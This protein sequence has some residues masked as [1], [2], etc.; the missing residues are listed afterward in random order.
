MPA[1]STGTVEGTQRLVATDPVSV[2]IVPSSAVEVNVVDKTLHRNDYWSGEFFLVYGTFAL[3]VVTAALA[4]YT[5]KLYRATVALG[6]DAKDSGEAQ[7]RAMSASILQADRAATAM[8]RTAQASFENNLHLKAST[9][10]QLRAY[11]LVKRITIGGESD[12]KLIKVFIRN[13]GKTPARDIRYWIRVSVA[14]VG[15]V[16]AP[17]YYDGVRR[18]D[19]VAHGDTHIVTYPD[20]FKEVKPTH[21]G[22]LA[23]Y[24][25][26]CLRYVDGFGEARETRFQFMRTG[27]DWDR[28]GEMDI[29]DYGNEAT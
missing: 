25:D 5:A 7:S 15:R 28:N 1:G 3:V 14:P 19:I 4:L 9:A 17:E 16:D 26:G 22:M 21:P 6:K 23:V 18:V 8:E 10:L 13:F 2:K 29:C 11:L 27:L 24:L 20:A 12:K